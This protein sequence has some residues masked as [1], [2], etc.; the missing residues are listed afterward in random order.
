MVQELLKFL[1]SWFS[2]FKALG[3][4]LTY[5]CLEKGTLVDWHDAIIG[6]LGLH[7]IIVDANP[8]EGCEK[9][10]EWK[11]WFWDFSEGVDMG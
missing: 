9:K 3:I 5:D 1:S 8:L 4:F 7:N 10:S 11:W 2:N 6:N